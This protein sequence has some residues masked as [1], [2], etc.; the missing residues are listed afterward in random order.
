MPQTKFTAK[1]LPIS[2]GSSLCKTVLVSYY[3]ACRSFTELYTCL[4]LL[5]AEHSP[6]KAELNT[7]SQHRKFIEKVSIKYYFKETWLLKPRKPG[8]MDLS[9]I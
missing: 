6:S 9:K 3:I 7:D 1:I 5:N 4:A 8:G 2:Y